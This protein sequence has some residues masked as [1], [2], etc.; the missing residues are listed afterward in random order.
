MDDAQG[1]FEIVVV[2]CALIDLLVIGAVVE[3]GGVGEALAEVGL[4]NAAVTYYVEYEVGIVGAD[5]QHLVCRSLCR[6]G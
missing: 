1:G 6:S 5:A 3:C 2:A 4:V